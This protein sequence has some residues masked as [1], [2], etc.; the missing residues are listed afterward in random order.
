MHT[1]LLG[2]NSS[3]VAIC[4]ASILESS[5]CP[6]TSLLMFSL[7]TSR[8]GT[9]W[10]SLF[11]CNIQHAYAAT[12]VSSTAVTQ[13]R[14]RY[15][16]ILVHVRSTGHCLSTGHYGPQV[17]TMY[18]L[19]GITYCCWSTD[20]SLHSPSWWKAKKCLPRC[21]SWAPLSSNW[22]VWPLAMASQTP[23]CR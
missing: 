23:S 22:Q 7:Q 21:C 4:T 20:L 1:W 2:C 16:R 5:L 13:I 10:Q 11:Y 12:L 3:K 15:A 8:Q 6:L 18:G 17:I 9:V 14:S 19:Q